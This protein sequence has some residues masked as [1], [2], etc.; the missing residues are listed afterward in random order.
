M[1]APAGSME[2][3]FLERSAKMAGAKEALGRAA[4]GLVAE[5]VADFSKTFALPEFVAE[6]SKSVV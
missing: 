1:A 2:R 4:A 3:T 6:Q 5:L